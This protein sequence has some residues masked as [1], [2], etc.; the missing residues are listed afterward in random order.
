MCRFTVRRP[1]WFM[2]VTRPVISAPK[3]ARTMSWSMARVTTIHLTSGAIGWAGRAPM[4]LARG[5]PIT[6]ELG[7][8]S[9]L[10]PAN[11]WERGGIRGGGHITGVGGTTSITITSASITLTFITTGGRASRTPNTG[12]DSTRGTAGN[13][14]TIGA[15]TS[16]HTQT[17]PSTM[18]VSRLLAP[19]T[20]TSTRTF[21]NRP[22][23]HVD[24]NNPIP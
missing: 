14:R 16:V 4:D 20:A 11:G 15:A 12:T 3:C 24:L 18:P 2:R 1:T 5:L 7:S 6:G 19:T 21:Q 13:G 10:A 8:A 9:D 23:R 22:R 17:T